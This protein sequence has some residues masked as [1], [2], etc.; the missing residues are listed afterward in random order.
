ML[1]GDEVGVAVRQGLSKLAKD[2]AGY[3]RGLVTILAS[4]AFAVRF[5]EG[6][7]GCLAGGADGLLVERLRHIPLPRTSRQA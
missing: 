3:L 5:P 6:S 1:A 4:S 2:H 7:K